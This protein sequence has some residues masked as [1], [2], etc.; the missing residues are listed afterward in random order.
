[1]DWWEI[2]TTYIAIK[3]MSYMGMASDIKIAKPDKKQVRNSSG[4]SAAEIAKAT[5]E[6]RTPAPD[7]SLP[8]VEINTVT[9]PNSDLVSSA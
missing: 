1:L 7:S 4:I 6:N 2:D 8:N 5:A 9:D 3:L